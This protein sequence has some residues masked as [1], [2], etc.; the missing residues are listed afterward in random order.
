MAD[1]KHLPDRESCPFLPEATRVLGPGDSK[2]R[3]GEADYFI[4]CLSCAQSLW[5]Q[6]KPAQALLQL[7]HALSLPAD[8]PT[9]WPLPYQAKIWLFTRRHEEGFLGNPV[10]HYQHLA[11][12]MSGP[13]SEL[14]SWR[15]WACFH[16][17]E[18]VLPAKAYPRDEVQIEK[19]SLHIPSWPKVLQNLSPITSQEELTQLRA[20]HP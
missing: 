10:R 1:R 18:S 13:N 17:A 8:S 9:P 12:R 14:R 2:S 3:R 11:S 15:A 6:G 20:L 19:E 7:N 5:L 4:T 16:L